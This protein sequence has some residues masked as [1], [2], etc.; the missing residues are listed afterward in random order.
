MSPKG[1]RG[2]RLNSNE[3][4]CEENNN[5]WSCYCLDRLVVVVAAEPGGGGGGRHWT[6]SGRVDFACSACVG[7]R[8]MVSECR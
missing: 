4:I 2:E 6:V 7:H 3:R 8:C 5:N 1:F